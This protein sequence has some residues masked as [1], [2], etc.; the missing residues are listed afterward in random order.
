[1]GKDDVQEPYRCAS[2][3]R[4]YLNA[5]VADSSV[6]PACGVTCSK[7]GGETERLCLRVI[8]WM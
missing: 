6:H 8:L 2:V 5:V 1:M 3:Q 4:P 7:R